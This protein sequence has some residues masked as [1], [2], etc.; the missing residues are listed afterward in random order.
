MSEIIHISYFKIDIEEK[1]ESKGRKWSDR[2]SENQENDQ[3]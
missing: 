1:I 3:G 2:N